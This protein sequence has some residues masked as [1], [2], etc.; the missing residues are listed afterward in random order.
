MYTL[1]SGA[2]TIK[3]TA[4]DKLGNTSTATVTFQLHVTIA[5]LVNAVSYGVSKGLIPSS[6]QSALVSTLQSAQAA[7]NAANST[8][9]KSYLNTFVT[10]VTSSTL[11]IVA[12]YVT[13]LVNWTQDLIARS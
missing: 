10:Q 12:S 8:S 11:K 7:L 6:S 1:S 4:V 2:H 5:G 3:I 9:E 13:L